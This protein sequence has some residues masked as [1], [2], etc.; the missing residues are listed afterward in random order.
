MGGH[1][2]LH[3]GETCRSG[4]KKKMHIFIIVLGLCLLV[5]V[6]TKRIDDDNEKLVKVSEDRI[7]NIELE[8]DEVNS[9]HSFEDSESEE[10]VLFF[11]GSA[12][13]PDEK[14]EEHGFITITSQFTGSNTTRH[15]VTHIP[16][17]KVGLLVENTL[18]SLSDDDF[19]IFALGSLLLP[20]MLSLPFTV[21]AVM[22]PILVTVCLTMF[23]FFTYIDNHL[24]F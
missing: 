16:M 23:S 6:N 10:N 1:F 14:S 19:L 5:F 8:A 3:W 2:S 12:S 18:G 17:E 9:P 20:L 11:S 13:F 7:Q 15:D 24:W 4:S 22:I 21:M